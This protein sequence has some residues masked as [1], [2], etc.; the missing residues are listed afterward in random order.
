MRKFFA[1]ACAEF[2][3]RKITTRK[4]ETKHEQTDGKTEIDEGDIG[5]ADVRRGGTS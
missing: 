5:G 2:A 1:E 3:A 4:G